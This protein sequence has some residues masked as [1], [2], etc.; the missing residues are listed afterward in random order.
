M[1]FIATITK[2]YNLFIIKFVVSSFENIFVLPDI[3]K[4][5]ALPLLRFTSHHWIIIFWS[6]LVLIG[7]WLYG[8]TNTWVNTYNLT[9]LLLE[10]Y[11]NCVYHT[12]WKFFLL[13]CENQVKSRVMYLLLFHLKMFLKL[14]VISKYKF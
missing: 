6:I 14:I 10:T 12:N 13:M 9:N 7:P 2:K 4:M 11:Q 5:S 8:N 3:L 1:Y